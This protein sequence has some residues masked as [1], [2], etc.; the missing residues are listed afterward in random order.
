[1]KYQKIYEEFKKKYTDDEIVDSMLLPANLT[2]KEKE[3]LSAE[4]KCI[5]RPYCATHTGPYCATHTGAYCA[6]SKRVDF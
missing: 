6:T 4:M 3:K 2:K 1:M 5:Y